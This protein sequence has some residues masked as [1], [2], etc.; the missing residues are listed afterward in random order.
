MAENID[1]QGIIDKDLTAPIGTDFNVMM[2]PGAQGVSFCTDD[3]GGTGAYGSGISLQRQKGNGSWVTLA[4]RTAN[5]EE[6]V[7]TPNGAKLRHF[8]EA[9]ATGIT[10]QTEVVGGY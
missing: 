7:E 4:T 3:D 5:G 1:L 8:P 10:A 9:G 2:S 6:I